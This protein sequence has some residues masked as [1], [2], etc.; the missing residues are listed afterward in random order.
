MNA[1]STLT[2]LLLETKTAMSNSALLCTKNMQCCRRYCPSGASHGFD[3]AVV[4]CFCKN[5]IVS[6]CKFIVFFC[7]FCSSL[8]LLRFML[9]LAWAGWALRT[10]FGR[11]RALV[12]PETCDDTWRWRRCGAGVSFG[13]FGMWFSRLVPFRVTALLLPNK[14]SVTSNKG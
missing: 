5:I 13:A 6:L 10:D 7:V 12:Q 1:A 8:S 9:C 2:A 14:C 11:R 4:L 3:S